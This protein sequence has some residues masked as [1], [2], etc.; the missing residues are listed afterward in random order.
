MLT[1]SIRNNV[2]VLGVFALAT[3]LLLASTFMGT[4]D[5]IAEAQRRAAQK[6]LLQ[7]FPPDSHDNDLLNDTLAVPD[8]Y[9]KTL[10]LEPGADIH[11][12][13]RDGQV[14]GFVVPAIAPDGYSGDIRLIMGIRPDGTLAGVRVLTHNETPGLGDKV[15]PR[16]SDWIHSFEG[17]S[18]G[19]PAREDWKVKKDG[20]VFDQFTGATITPRAVVG[21]VRKTLLFFREHREELLAAARR[22]VPLQETES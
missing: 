17:R 12:A 22:G 11:I 4:K 14:T 18:L 5:T 3:A 8:T 9:L 1:R 16:K 20:G 21:Q 2:L 15:E 7:I 13:R 10:N 6:S 19:D